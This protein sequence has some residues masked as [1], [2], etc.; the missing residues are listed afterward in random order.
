MQSD[1][2]F[3]AWASLFLKHYDSA[4]IGVDAVPPANGEVCP[5]TGGVIT[6]A[7]QQLLMAVEA[8]GVPT[9]VSNNLRQIAADNG[10][11]VTADWT[12][13]DIIAALKEK[14]RAGKAGAQ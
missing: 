4:E 3:S 13:N 2:Q 10:I 12:P 6:V 5:L 7:A 8:G 11:Q 9:F 14:L 1:D